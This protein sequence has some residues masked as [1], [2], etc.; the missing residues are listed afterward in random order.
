MQIKSHPVM[1]DIVQTIRNTFYPVDD[2][3]HM[4]IPD[5]VRQQLGLVFIY[6]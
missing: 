4:N 6:I 1:G 2:V 3:C 5:H